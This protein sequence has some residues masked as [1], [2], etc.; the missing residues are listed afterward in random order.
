[1]RCFWPPVQSAPQPCCCSVDN[2]SLDDV[3][4]AFFLYRVR[5]GQRLC[6]VL[7]LWDHLNAEL[8]SG[9]FTHST[10]T[11]PATNGPLGAVPV[12][13]ETER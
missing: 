10:V 2:V 6:G 13:R 12:G 7:L 1:M 5:K 8:W 11:M 3:F 4:T 9:R